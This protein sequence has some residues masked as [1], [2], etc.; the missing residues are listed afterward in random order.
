MCI[1]QWD[2]KGLRSNR[3]NFD[4]L[5]NK[6]QP[7]VLCLQEIKLEHSL[8]PKTYQCANYDCYN[9]A[10]RRSKQLPF[11][12]VSI[13]VKKNLFHNPITIR[14]V[15]T[16]SSEHLTTQDLSR[17]SRDLNGH[18]II[19]GDFNGH[20]YSWSSLSNDIKCDVMG[21][22]TENNLCILNNG[23][24]TYLKTQP[25]HLPNPTSAMDFSICTPDLALRCTWEVLPDTLG[26]DH[27]PVLISVS[28]ISGDTDQGG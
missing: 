22:F 25:Q 21:R 5:I 19:T 23:S 9:K 3:R 7:E 28:P 14:S 11:G 8:H 6:I 17:F 15:Y 26:S 12:G 2:I 24:P 1:L 4:I 18:I 16:P 13:F 20:N 27:Y 10:L